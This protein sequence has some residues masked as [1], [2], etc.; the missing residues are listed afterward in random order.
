M[1]KLGIEFKFT[2]SSPEKVY[3]ELTNGCNL[4][5]QFCF[6][7]GWN[8][9]IFELDG[10]ILEK[11]KRGLEGTRVKEVILGGI[12][13]PTTASNF[14]TGVKLFK[15]Y[16]LTLTT[17]GT[18]L[19]EKGEIISQGIKK[20]IVSV[21]GDED[22]F[23]QI[24]NT[25]LEQVLDGIKYIKGINKGIE[26]LLQFVIGRENVDK[27]KAVVDI[28]EKLNL[29]G[30][31]FSNIIPG[32][33]RDKDKY[34]Y[35]LGPNP[36]L[37]RVFNEVRN[38][39]FKKG[40]NII[41]PQTKI[42][43]LRKC[44]FIEEGSIFINSLGEVCPCYRFAHNSKEYVFGR[45]KRISKHSYGSVK[46]GDI[47]TIWNSKSYL[48]FRLTLITENYPSCLDCDLVDG[49]DIVNQTTWDCE[50][51]SPTCG[52]CLWSRGITICP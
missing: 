31:I 46:D 42:K 41:Y 52:D 38:Y 48:D 39:S 6:R 27:M 9:G 21:D 34:L 15:D 13:E 24:R 35:T 37:D 12:G 49:C 1:K 22:K 17:N 30:V 50:G 26:V 29:Q 20:I 28:C 18:L 36:Y 2:E 8:E 11:I 25:P 51:M 4:N 16:N 3:L 10:E 32:Q 14:E 47:L 19:K 5:C 33:Q 45:E 43:T 7:H 23:F 44:G 40:V